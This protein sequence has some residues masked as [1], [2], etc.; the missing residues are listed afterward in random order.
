M[1]EQPPETQEDDPLVAELQAKL[2]KLRRRE[3]RNL[4]QA[5]AHGFLDGVLALLRPGDIV[6]DC[7]ANIG[8]VSARLAATGATVIAFEPDPFAFGKLSERLADCANVTMH[9]QAVST[10]AGSLRLMRASN[11]DDN[12]KGGSVKSTLLSGGRG[13]SED[14]SI[15]VEVIDFVAFLRDMLAKSGPVAFVKMDIE[16]AEL[17]L[18]G[19]M[20]KAGLF[21]D[22]R[23]LVAE[24]HERKFK[25]LRSE[26]RALREAFTEKYSSQHVNLDWI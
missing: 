7:G 5:R 16:G 21:A 23:C 19:E 3:Q 18:L 8:D 9:Q 13:I 14:D 26:Y 2:S 15:E 1:T 4:R 11:F 24:T 10:E 17:A 6:I 12:P 25:D 22:I 20:D